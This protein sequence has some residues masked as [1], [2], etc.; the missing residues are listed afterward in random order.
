MG[1]LGFSHNRLHPAYRRARGFRA[2]S[3]T[4]L[5]DLEL[6]AAFR[7]SDWRMMEIVKLGTAKGTQPLRTKLPPPIG[8]RSSWAPV[9]Q[10]SS[11]PSNFELL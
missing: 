7:A 6:R 10:G 11:D 2:P 8:L 5:H 1:L 9:V 4:H 3:R